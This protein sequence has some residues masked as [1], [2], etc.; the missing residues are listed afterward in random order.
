M[1][2]KTEEKSMNDK[3][4]LASGKRRAFLKAGLRAFALGGLALTGTI[5]GLRTSTHESSS[6]ACA[7]E[8]PC[9]R[10]RQLPGCAE[11][12]AARVREESESA[13]G[14]PGP[15]DGGGRRD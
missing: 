13:A 6:P 11:P 5:L 12:R 9:R 1:R 4:A 2:G 10:C 8:L 7:L 14:R 15:Q 3:I